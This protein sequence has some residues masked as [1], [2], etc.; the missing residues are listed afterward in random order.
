[1][2]AKLS[3]VVCCG[4]SFFFPLCGWLAVV[5]VFFHSGALE[6]QSLCVLFLILESRQLQ[7]AVIFHVTAELF[8]LF[9]LA[10]AGKEQKPEHVC[11][12]GEG[13]SRRLALEL[14]C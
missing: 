2:L 5:V 14:M 10:E 12:V 7:L 11:R 9:L 8:L 1:V 13:K 6:W 4:Q 3:P